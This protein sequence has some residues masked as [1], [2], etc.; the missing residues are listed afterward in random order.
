MSRLI[1]PLEVG[2]WEATASCSS[3][4]PDGFTRDRRC[5]VV[6]NVQNTAEIEQTGISTVTG[7]PGQYR[8]ITPRFLIV[9]VP[10]GVHLLPFF[11]VATT[12]NAALLSSS[13]GVLLDPF[14]ATSL[15]PPEVFFWSEKALVST[16]STMPLSARLRRRMNSSANLRPSSV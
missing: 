9:P 11:F 6:S 15:Q 3:D 2:K 12:L 7:S 1:D 13:L 16:G 10:L 8:Y 5:T 14:L 4:N